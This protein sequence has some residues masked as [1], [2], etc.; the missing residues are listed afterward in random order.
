MANV[1]AMFF[2][3]FF[4]VRV[5][6]Y[7]VIFSISPC[8]RQWFLWKSGFPCKALLKLLKCLRDGL[9]GDLTW[10]KEAAG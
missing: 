5:G 6:S 1:S 4:F 9:V 3:V 2:M 10:L 8:I 7:S